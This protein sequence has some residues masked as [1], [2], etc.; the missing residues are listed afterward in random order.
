[1][2]YSKPLQSNKALNV[3]TLIA[4]SLLEI[5][6]TT[7]SYVAVKP[8]INTATNMLIAQIFINI[9]MNK[10]YTLCQIKLV[11]EWLKKIEWEV[12][13]KNRNE[14]GTVEH[15]KVSGLQPNDTFTGDTAYLDDELQTNENVESR[16]FIVSKLCNVVSLEVSVSDDNWNDMSAT[17]LWCKDT[18]HSRYV[19]FSSNFVSI[20]LTYASFSISVVAL[21]INIIVMRKLYMTSTVPGVNMR[22][23]SIS[24]LMAEVVFMFGIGANDTQH[25]CYFVGIILHYLWLTI[26][27]FITIALIWI[28]KHLFSLK[29]RTNQNDLNTRFH[30]HTLTFLGLIIPTLSV[31]PAILL[32]QYKVLSVRYGGN[33]CFPQRFQGNLYFFTGPVMFLLSVNIICIVSVV[34]QMAK[35]RTNIGRSRVSNMSQASRDVKVYT[36]LVILSLLVWSTGIVNSFLKEEVL[37]FVFTLL[38]GLHGTFITIA[39]LTTKTVMK[40]FRNQTDS[41][42]TKEI[43][44]T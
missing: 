30:R 16:E 9:E 42:G 23:V 28:S 18:P 44:S 37:E 34:I 36:R 24:M 25:I 17:A 40:H 1:M 8:R 13:I 32:D 35:T 10:D 39:N 31:V 15:L 6:T 3:A 38:C 41:V 11:I 12:K 14:T 20:V 43:R 2:S 22:N 26:F 5:N 33:V 4:W 29:T 7:I 27:A 21:F 19:N